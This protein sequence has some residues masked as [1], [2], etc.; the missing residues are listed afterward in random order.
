MNNQKNRPHLIP[1]L[2]SVREALISDRIKVHEI[3]ISEGRDKARVK[4]LLEI[5]GRKRI[6]VI[7]KR[8]DLLDDALPSTTHQGIIAVA[9][10]FAYLEIEDLI[11]LSRKKEGHGLLIAADHITDEGNLGALIRTA[12]FFGAD[13]IIIPKDRSA[14]VS[15]TAMKRSAG[16]YLNIPVARVVNL[17]RALD[18]LTEEGFWIIGTAGEGTESIYRFDW[19]RDICLVLGSEDKGMGHMTRGKCHQ[20]VSIPALGAAES[21][22]ISVACG[23]ILSEILRQRTAG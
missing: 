6:P 23:V 21:L 8:A 2:H 11:D 10:E 13:G 7:Y 4:E 3:W 12:C 5:A 19:K 20:I 22:N 18:L 1:G 14:Q 17:S 15:H 16:N 9:G